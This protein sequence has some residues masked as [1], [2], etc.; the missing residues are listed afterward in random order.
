R[1]GESRRKARRSAGSP[2]RTA[3]SA[4]GATRP[5]ASCVLALAPLLP[6]APVRQGRSRLSL[7]RSSAPF[8]AGAGQAAPAEF[9]AQAVVEAPLADLGEADLGRAAADAHDVAVTDRGPLLAVEGE[10]DLFALRLQGDLDR[11][12]V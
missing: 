11:A 5:A 6:A 1:R 3:A 2:R 10:V 4:S 7:P 12:G 8:G 9:A